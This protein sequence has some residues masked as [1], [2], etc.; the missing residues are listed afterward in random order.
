MPKY[1]AMASYNSE[2]IKGLLKA[3]EQRVVVLSKSC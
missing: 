2:G 1:L 3:G